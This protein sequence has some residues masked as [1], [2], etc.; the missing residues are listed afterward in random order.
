MAIGPLTPGDPL[1]ELKGKYL[2]GPPALLPKDTH[3]KVA[4]LALGFS[5][6]STDAVGAWIYRFLQDFDHHPRVISFD[7]PMLGGIARMGKGV[8][9]NS[10]R[11]NLSPASYRHVITGS[12]QTGAWKKRVGFHSPKVAYLILIDG[13]GIVRWLHGGAFD[14]ARYQELAQ[15]IRGLIADDPVGPQ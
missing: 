12:N 3:G 1:P 2:S 13:E 14:E 5:L 8:V 11:R 6:D 15:A 10:M 4:L 7:L 9:D